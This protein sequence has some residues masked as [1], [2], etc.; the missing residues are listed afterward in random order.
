MVKADGHV[1][2][3]HESKENGQIRVRHE[4]KE[5]G[6][7][8][9]YIEV[10]T[11]DKD[12][13]APY[14]NHLNKNLDLH[15]GTAIH[16]SC[17]IPC[18]LHSS[19]NVTPTSESSC[20]CQDDLS[21][22]CSDQYLDDQ[23]TE[24]TRGSSNHSSRNSKISYCEK[25]NL[26]NK[27]HSSSSSPSHSLGGACNVISNSDEENVDQ[28]DG[29]LDPKDDSNLPL[30]TCDANCLNGGFQY[31]F[32]G[33]EA[34][35]TGKK[36]RNGGHLAPLIVSSIQGPLVEYPVSDGFPSNKDKRVRD[37]FNIIVEDGKE[38]EAASKSSRKQCCYHIFVLAILLMANLLNYTDRY[39]VAGKALFILFLRFH[40]L[41]L[42]FG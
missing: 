26:I 10:D 16:N 37:Q 6:K 32:A 4:S 38:E 33:Q 12:N 20:S 1:R 24:E 27:K 25:C 9:N 7:G 11:R 14:L 28:L 23:S 41:L 15:K 21:D 22:P 2:I 30:C 34:L 35:N 39:T 29:L 3:R 36:G 40:L 31:E 8:I 5:K 13:L 42:L 18:P 17:I 19:G